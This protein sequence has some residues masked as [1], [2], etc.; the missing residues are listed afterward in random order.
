[1]KNYCSHYKT[2][3]VFCENDDESWGYNTY[4]IEKLY[5][6]DDKKKFSN[7]LLL[8]ENMG[9]EIKSPGIDSL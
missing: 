4:S 2:I 1:M 6:L 7:G 8:F 5:P 9:K 3:D